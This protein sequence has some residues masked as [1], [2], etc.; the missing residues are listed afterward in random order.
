[1]AFFIW[2]RPGGSAVQSSFPPLFT[3]PMASSI[4]LF[5]SSPFATSSHLSSSQ[6]PATASS[7]RRFLIKCSSEPPLV[8]SIKFNKRDFLWGITLGSLI[9]KEPLKSVAREV[10]VGSYL[11]PSP[12]DPAFV[13]F[14]ATPKDTPALRAGNSS[15]F[16]PAIFSW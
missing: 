5:L 16:N 6:E 7:Q 11:P 10:E 2:I 13:V 4:S 1:M 3:S 14:K 8:P 12:S 9:L 15:L